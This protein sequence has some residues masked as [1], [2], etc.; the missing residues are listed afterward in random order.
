MFFWTA[1]H[2]NLYIISENVILISSYSLYLLNF[3]VLSLL[4]H[5][6]D[7]LWIFLLI[8]GYTMQNIYIVNFVDYRQKLYIYIFNKLDNRGMKHV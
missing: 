6:Y 2:E 5:I 8:L 1:N 3:I 4:L 7:I